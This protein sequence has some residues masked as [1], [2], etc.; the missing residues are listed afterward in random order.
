MLN[1]E[2]HLSCP[3]VVPNIAMEND[4]LL[5]VETQVSPNSLP[6]NLRVGMPITDQS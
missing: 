5:E 3:S 2:T 1:G 6:F 4:M